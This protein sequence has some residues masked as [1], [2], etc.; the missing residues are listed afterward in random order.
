MHLFRIPDTG[1]SAFGL[2]LT[3][4]DRI[5]L[6]VAGVRHYEFLDWH[7]REVF[8]DGATSNEAALEALLEDGFPL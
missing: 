2:W 1:D 3:D 4:V 6:R 8:Q 7:W 5:L